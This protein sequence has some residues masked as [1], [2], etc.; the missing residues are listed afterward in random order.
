MIKQE[1]VSLQQINLRLPKFPKT[2]GVVTSPTGA[3]IHDM[4]SVSLK[5]DL[6]IRLSDGSVIATPKEVYY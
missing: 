3:A 1:C 5:E 6:C 2:I 4:K